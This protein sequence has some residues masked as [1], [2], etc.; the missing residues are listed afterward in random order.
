MKLGRWF[1]TLRLDQC[2]NAEARTP[3]SL[4]LGI[5][6]ML[7]RRLQALRLGI[8]RVAMISVVSGVS[9]LFSDDLS[10]VIFRQSTELLPKFSKLRG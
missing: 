1:Q 8:T 2:S 9:T 7:R 4:R 10:L 6:V 5:V 3:S